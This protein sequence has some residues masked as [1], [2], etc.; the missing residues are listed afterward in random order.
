MQENHPL[1]AEAAEG[2]ENAGQGTGSADQPPCVPE[3]EALLGGCVGPHQC[4]S[5][6]D[7]NGVVRP[8]AWGSLS[9]GLP[10]P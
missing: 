8:R 6:R 3:P 4:L 9:G 10:R 5:A 7:E 1:L 2:K